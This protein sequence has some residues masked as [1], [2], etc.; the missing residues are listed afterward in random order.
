MDEF[1]WMMIVL[2]LAAGILVAPLVSLFLCL[3]IRRRQAELARDLAGL[4]A[5][6]FDRLAKLQPPRSEDTS[7]PP[8]VAQGVPATTSIPVPPPALKATPVPIAAPV[9]PAIP[10]TPPAVSPAPPLSWPRPVREP[11]A[12][13]VP[14]REPSRFETAAR[15]ILSRIWNWI[16]VGEEFRRP[17]ASVE[18]AVATNWLVRVG[19]L[20]VVVGVGFFLDYTSTRGWV[21]PLG[22]VSLALMAGSALL[23]GGIRLLGRRYHLIAQGLLGAGLAVWYAAIFTAFNRYQLIGAGTAFAMMAA[24]TGGAG[25]MAVRFNSM[26]VAILGILGGY[27]TPAMLSA[28]E[29]NFIGLYSYMLLLGAGVLGIAHRRHWHLLNALAFIATWLLVAASLDH[30]FTPERFWQVMPFLAA[31]FVLFST[32]IFIYQVLHAIKATLIDLIMLI[33]NAALFFGFSYEL[34]RKTYSTE[35]AAAVALGLACFYTGHLYF[36]LRKKSCDRGLSLG[37]IALASFFLIVTLPLL[38]SSQWLTLCWSVQALVLLWL[39]AK[40][41]SRFLQTVACGLYVIVFVRFF[42]IDMAGSFGHSVPAGTGLAA[43]LRMLAERLVSFGVPVVSVALAMRLVQ[44]PVPPAASLALVPSNDI[45]PLWKESQT[46]TAV[47]TALFAMLFLYLHVELNRTLLFLWPPLCLP[48]LSGLWVAAC[49]V[50]LLLF[51]RFGY[52][53]LLALLVVFTAGTLCKLL[54]VDLPGWGASA[55]HLRYIIPSGY[56]FLDA[57]MRLVDN[58]VILAFLVYAFRLLHRRGG[59]MAARDMFGYGSIVL[60]LAYTSLEVNSFLAHFVPGLRAGGIS[61]YWGVF[62]LGLITGGL[63]RRVRPLRLA[64]LVLFALVALKVF[65]ADLALLDPLYKI[66]AFTLLGTVLL[67]GAFVYL[68][69]QDRFNT[70]PSEKGES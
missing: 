44:K 5:G 9:P 45:K 36:F 63:V 61:V 26:L 35:W 12:V 17:G 37:F 64:G 19:V 47:A 29:V 11:A 27:G 68:R 60:L 55:A 20:I 31:F 62:A 54:A 25:F 22:K 2:L 6:L 50:L 8:A 21:G 24:V 23:A 13:H 33:L 28:G 10:A 14:S 65:F 49:L 69:F 7:S 48:V 51:C 42:A 18:Y 70:L 1:F 41:E 38:L 56:S 53:S 32:V 30:G 58:G 16:I 34:I 67:A 43:Y 57:G 4:K 52:R 40:L 46:I 15:Q 66:V 39:A 3:G 59:A